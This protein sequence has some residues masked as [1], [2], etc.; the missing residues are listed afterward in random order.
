MHPTLSEIETLASQAG[1]ILRA[2][3]IPRPGFQKQF[4]IEYKSTID[5]VT[6][7]DKRSEAYLLAEIRRRYPEHRI[8]TEESGIFSGEDSC[9][10][11]IDPLDGT[12]NYSH[13][14]TPFAVSI[15]YAEN[16]RSLLGV[17]YDPIL[18]EC[19]SAERGRG[20]YLNGKPVHVADTQSF[21]RSLFVTCFP[22]DVQTN[23]ENNLD[24]YNR[25][26]MLTQGVRQSGCAALGMCYVAAGRFD[27]YWELRLSSWD[28]AAG[29]LIAEEAGAIATKVNGDPD[30][31][32][33]PYS[34]LTANPALYPQMLK[35]LHKEPEG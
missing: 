20:A 21:D 17:V 4:Q 18:D 8:E 5:P 30:Y 9:V 27:G 6:E 12:L 26:S 10:W 25:F 23:P 14:V 3:Y 29:A 15:G 19:F 32:R 24:Y 28:L 33:P 2:S 16:D 1:E 34:M 35:I 13:N 11:Y 31:L 7:V 22:H